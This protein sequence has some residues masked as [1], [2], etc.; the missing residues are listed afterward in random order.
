MTVKEQYD[1][2]VKTFT[3]KGEDV[4]KAMLFDD[5]WEFR[6]IELEWKKDKAT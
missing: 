4:D 1:E 6:K 2:Y 3:D 5:W